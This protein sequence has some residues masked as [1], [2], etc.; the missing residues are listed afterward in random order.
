M[1]A[2]FSCRVDVI[3]KQGRKITK[4]RVSWWLKTVDEQKVQW[5]AQKG[6][7]GDLFPPTLPV[8]LIEELDG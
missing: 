4:L 3:E 6:Q 7:Q 8:V 2:P 1:L 5:H